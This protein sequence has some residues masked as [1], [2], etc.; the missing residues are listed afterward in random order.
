MNLVHAVKPRYALDAAIGFGSEAAAL[1]LR[2]NEW[3]DHYTVTAYTKTKSIEQEFRELV[4]RWYANC[5]P[6]SSP[7]KLI[8]DSAYRR[9]IGLGKAVVPLILRELRSVPDLWGPALESITGVNAA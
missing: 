4:D 8:A 3:C 9:I 7:T 6:T 2:L 1:R 5:G